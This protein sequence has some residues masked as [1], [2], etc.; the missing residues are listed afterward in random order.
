MKHRNPNEL[1]KKTS[2]KHHTVMVITY[3]NFEKHLV[4]FWTKN[5]EIFPETSR[6]FTKKYIFLFKNTIK[7]QN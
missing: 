2:N 5:T 3:Q 1:K 6:L 7:V 4:N